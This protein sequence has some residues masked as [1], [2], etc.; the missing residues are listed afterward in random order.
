VPWVGFG[1][2]I[3]STYTQPNIELNYQGTIS[4]YWNTYFA[5]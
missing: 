2:H 4:Y 1:T 3:S 5:K